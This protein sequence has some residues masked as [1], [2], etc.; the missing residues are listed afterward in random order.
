[1]IPHLAQPVLPITRLTPV[2]PLQ[3]VPFSVPSVWDHLRA[4]P[5]GCSSQQFSEENDL[6][7]TSTVSPSA[8]ARAW[9]SS[10]QMPCAKCATAPYVLPGSQPLISSGGPYATHHGIRRQRI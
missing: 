3:A 5:K 8:A 9:S 6:P 1:M 10:E 7:S 2:S 4:S